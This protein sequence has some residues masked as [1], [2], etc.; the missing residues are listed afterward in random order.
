M[1]PGQSVVLYIAVMMRRRKDLLERLDT[2]TALKNCGSKKLCP[3][4]K[5]LDTDAIDLL[6]EASHNIISSPKQRIGRHSI[7]RLEPYKQELLFLSKP[8]NSMQRKKKILSSQA[9]AG[10]IT[11]LVSVST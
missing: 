9:G 2:L 11:L 6:S 10:L 1:D 5:Y 8:K 7:S 4:F 3:I